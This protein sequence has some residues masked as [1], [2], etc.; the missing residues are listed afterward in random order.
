MILPL[1]LPSTMNMRDNARYIELYNELLLFRYGINC[2]PLWLRC[3]MY[4]VAIK[5]FSLDQSHS[6]ITI[7][8]N[9]PEAKYICSLTPANATWNDGSMNG[10]HSIRP[11]NTI[12]LLEDTIYRL[13]I[14]TR[15]GR[16]SYLTEY[17]ATMPKRTSYNPGGRVYI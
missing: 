12:K 7:Y 13:S 1:L 17:F 5:N 4:Q 9:V 16:L 6:G 3:D 15:F 8:E 14:C 10:D 2:D 11:E